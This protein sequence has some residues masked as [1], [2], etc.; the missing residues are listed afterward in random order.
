MAVNKKGKPI[1]EYPKRIKDANGNKIRVMNAAEEAKIL[2][3]E[4]PKENKKEE[5]KQEGKGWS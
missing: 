4:P 3:K 5:K 2:G 1:V